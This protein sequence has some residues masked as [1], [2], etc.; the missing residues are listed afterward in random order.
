MKLQCHNPQN[1]DNQSALYFLKPAATAKM[2]R[3][4]HHF[5]TW[6]TEANIGL[7]LSSLHVCLG[8]FYKTKLHKILKF[9]M[10]RQSN[11]FTRTYISQYI[12]LCSLT[13]MK[14]WLRPIGQT[15]HRSTKCPSAHQDEPKEIL[16]ESTLVTVSAANCWNMYIPY[17]RTH[18]SHLI[19]QTTFMSHQH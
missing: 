11:L 3:N 2:L 17:S 18:F 14:F 1:I 8:L 4:G 5:G 10:Y 15:C 13:L 7:Y 16:T 6:S 12:Y 9:E 19:L